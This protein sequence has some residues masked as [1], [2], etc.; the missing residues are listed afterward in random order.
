MLAKR[1]ICCLDVDRG[2]VVKGIKFSDLRDA[3]DPV[4]LAARYNTE[5]ADELTFLDITASHEGRQTMLEVA[6]RTAEEV[7]IPF[8]VG[9]G[10]RTVDD[11]RAVLK[12]GADKVAVTT[13]AIE[14]PTLIREAAERFGSQCV[15]LSMDVKRGADTP[16]GKTSWQCYSH[17]GRTPTDID[18]LDWAKR[19]QDLGAGEFLLNSMDADG[20]MGGYDIALCRTIADAVSAPVI[21]S[22]GAGTPEHIHAALTEGRA[23][24]ALI[25]SITHFSKHALADIKRYLADR[26]V[27]VRPTHIAD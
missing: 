5:G 3:G 26:G 12:T 11:F 7:F 17:G 21:A 6:S 24:A 1:I 18:A 22:G 16:S 10:I 15:V 4:E 23:E 27:P 2:R 14:N 8:T 19:A 13:A 9:G 20:T 25:A